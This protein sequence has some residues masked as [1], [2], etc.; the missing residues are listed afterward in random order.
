MTSQEAIRLVER[1]R[2]KLD[3]D[4]EMTFETAVRAI[5]QHKKNPDRPGRTEDRVAWI[6]TYRSEWG[7]VEVHVDDARG[8]ILR[9]RR[10]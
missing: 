1:R 2:K 7:F 5:V 9:V 6:L 4:P 10:G 3:I 8:R